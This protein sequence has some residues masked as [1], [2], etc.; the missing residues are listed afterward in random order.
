MNTLI[1]NTESRSEFKFLT[2]LLKKLNIDARVLSEE[3]QED[4]FD[5]LSIQAV[6]EEETIDFNEFAKSQGF[7]RKVKLQ[8]A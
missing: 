3:E 1:V 5:I 8:N 4:I 7:E 6:K 2:N